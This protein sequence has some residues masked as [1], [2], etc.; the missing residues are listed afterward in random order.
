MRRDLEEEEHRRGAAGCSSSYFFSLRSVPSLAK[1]LRAGGRIF[2]DEN[3]EI[4]RKREVQPRER[5]MGE[6]TRHCVV[7]RWIHRV[8]TVWIRARFGTYNLTGKP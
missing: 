1:F 7:R 8:Y 2:E 4:S 5:E 6:A 3:K